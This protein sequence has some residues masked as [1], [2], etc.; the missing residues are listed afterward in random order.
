MVPAT[1]LWNSTTVTGRAFTAQGT[2]DPSVSN[3]ITTLEG[4]DLAE[5]TGVAAVPMVTL[6]HKAEDLSQAG[7]GG[8]S[9]P[10]SSSSSSTPNAASGLIRE[11]HHGAVGILFAVWT[12]MALVLGFVPFV[13]ATF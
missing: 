4:D 10:S 11:T 8:N 3:Y 7:D 1:Y 5:Y 2:A 12:L 9:S 6:V 13:A